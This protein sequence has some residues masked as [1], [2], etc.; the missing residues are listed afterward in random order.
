MLLFTFSLIE[1]D[2]IPIRNVQQDAERYNSVACADSFVS[3]NAEQTEK[4]E[5]E[6]GER[7]EVVTNRIQ[8]RERKNMQR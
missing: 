4:R 8:E 7:E 3:V 6:R 2:E 1:P 5:R